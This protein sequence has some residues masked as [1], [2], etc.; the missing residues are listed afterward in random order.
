MD[1]IE[2]IFMYYTRTSCGPS[3]LSQLSNIPTYLC[4]NELIGGL[5]ALS[6]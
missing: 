4:C 1:R 5:N 3:D 6:E 2:F